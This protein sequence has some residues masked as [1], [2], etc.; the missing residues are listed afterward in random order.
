MSLCFPNAK[1]KGVLCYYFLNPENSVF[2]NTVIPVCTWVESRLL[3]HRELLSGLIFE[4]HWLFLFQQSPVFDSSS[5]RVELY[6]PLRIYAGSLWDLPFCS[7]CAYFHSHVYNCP[8]MFRHYFTIVI[9][10]RWILKSFNHLSCDDPED[11]G[12][13][14]VI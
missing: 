10:N 9:H 1:V 7:L 6:E 5:A 2:L 11:T 12:G 14:S 3:E 8:A 4:K 13:R